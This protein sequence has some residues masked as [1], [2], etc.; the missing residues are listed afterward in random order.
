MHD[1][2]STQNKMT[3]P[4]S[5]T[6]EQLREMAAR[7]QQQIE[8]QQQHLVAKEQRLKFLKQ[9][10]YQQHQMASEYDRLRRLRDK[11]ETQELKL[12]KLRALRGQ[13]D[14]ANANNNGSLTN[15][16]DSIRLLFNEKEK[17][18]AMAVVKVDELTGQLEEL[19]SGKLNFNYPPQVVELEKLRR[20]LAY[21]RQLNEQQ[22]NMIQQQRA[23]LSMGQDEMA[24]IDR[25]IAELQDRL[26]RKRMMNQ[27]LANQI[28]AATTAKQAQL[29]AIQAGLSNK[30]KTKPVSTVEPFQRSIVAQ[31]VDNHHVSAEDLKPTITNQESEPPSGN[32][33]Y[34]PKYQTLPYNTK[35]GHLNNAKAQKIEQ[36]KQEKEN[37]NIGFSEALP[38]PPPPMYG[39]G[40][41]T[42]YQG[43]YGQGI[44]IVA[45]LPQTDNSTASSN[46]T[47]PISL[48]KPISSVAPVFSSVSNSRPGYG[49][50]ISSMAD[51][52]IFSPPK[53]SST[54]ISSS[55]QSNSETPTKLRP[56]LPPKPI[57]TNTGPMPPPRQSPVPPVHGEDGTS[58]DDED[59]P[60]PPPTT[61]PPLESPT[62]D[63]DMLNGNRDLSV[64]VSQSVNLDNSG[65]MV[66]TT[67]SENQNQQ[68]VHVSIN[69]RIE[70]PP[71]FHFPEDEAPPSDLIS[72][73]EYPMLPR[74]VTDNAALFPMV[75]QIYKEFQDLAFEEKEQLFSRSPEESDEYSPDNVPEFDPIPSASERVGVKSIIEMSKKGNVKITGQTRHN[76]TVSFDPLALLLDA[77]LEGE[78][79]L[80]KK[81]AAEVTNPSAANDEG[82]TALHNAICAGHLEIVQFL[83]LFGCDVNAQDSD[84]WTPLHCAASCNNL[85]MVRFLV[86][87]GACIFATTLSDHET[88]AEKCE[89]DEEGFDGCSEYLYHI[90]EKL[91][92]MNDGIVYAVYTYEAINSDELSFVESERMMVLRKG[93]ELEKEWWWSK[94]ESGDHSE[95][96]IPRNLIGL[97]PRVPAP[98]NG[99]QQQPMEE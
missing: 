90:Q 27:Q 21:R 37:N 82:I 58:V 31:P 57:M 76:R 96:Y 26:T 53:L 16:L 99:N 68:N 5:L 84:G 54:P 77:S 24:R 72:G 8:A 69:R 4:Q 25:R 14:H 74:D 56:A 22:N 46:M 48:G 36:L 93:D 44:G 12:R 35:F 62:P 78:L 30:N 91:G 38:R 55:N 50:P 52:S 1:G 65:L 23:Q 75:N 43:N 51:S 47:I 94:K 34:D 41:G 17:E 66:S 81:T 79:D 2:S 83:V 88:A 13:P 40:R 29:R 80:V 28:N 15:D 89:E 45:P 85:A 19:R 10:E 70:M 59:L 39:G 42:D 60:P 32:K 92:I 20:E 11:V 97:Y 67:S 33:N 3:A 98:N 86:E 87:H 95:G 7:Q 64:D 9:Q 49:T 18:L 63:S 71:A 61:E 73:A 6:I